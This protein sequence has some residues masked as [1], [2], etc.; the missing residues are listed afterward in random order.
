MPFPYLPLVLPPLIAVAGAVAASIAVRRG[1][2][3]VDAMVAAEAV[4]EASRTEVEVSDLR[5]ARHA[6]DRRGADLRG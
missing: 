1:G 4:A 6:Q 5:P 2:A 3:R